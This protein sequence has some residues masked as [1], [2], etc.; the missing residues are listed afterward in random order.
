MTEI[1]FYHFEKQ[2]L[3]QALPL[4][5][6]K[7]YKTGQKIVVRLADEK[8]VEKINTILWTYKTD[9]FLPHGSKKDGHPNQHPI[10]ITHKN[11]NPNKATI[12]ISAQN[13]QES[14]EK[15][16]LNTFNLCCEMLDGRNEKEI[17]SARKRWKTY[18]ESEHTITYWHQNEAGGWSKKA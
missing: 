2:T 5:L 3:E 15:N 17:K 11:E 7:A 9:K 10:W 1:R 14:E 8:E 16:D 13:V 18:K 6:E 4:I 12:L